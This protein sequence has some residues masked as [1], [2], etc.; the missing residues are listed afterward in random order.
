MGGFKKTSFKA[1]L[2]YLY[3]DQCPT[4]SLSETIDLIELGNFL[5]LPRL[6]TLAE[7]MMVCDLRVSIL[8]ERDVTISV[9]SLLIP[10]KVILKI[11]LVG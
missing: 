6:V 1:L 9:A 10:T 5:C 8:K 4:L 11:T 7:K 2:M 3:T